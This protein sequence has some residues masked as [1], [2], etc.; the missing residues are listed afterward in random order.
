MVTSAGCA[1]LGASLAAE[2]FGPPEL[3]PADDLVGNAIRLLPALMVLAIGGL[4]GF[5]VGVTVLPPVL[6]WA[7][8]WSHVALTTLSIIGLEIMVVPLVIWMANRLD[9]TSAWAPI[10]LLAVVILGG[11]VPAAARWITMSTAS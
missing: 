10:E 11:A 6:M 8:G 5:V 4:M 2:V 7:S 3:G 9:E 1:L